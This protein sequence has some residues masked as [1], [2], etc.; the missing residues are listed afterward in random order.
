M[1]AGG[2]QRGSRDT[3]R[4]PASPRDSPGTPPAS[5]LLPGVNVPAQLPLAVAVSGCPGLSSGQ[6]ALRSE[7][8]STRSPRLPS[9]LPGLF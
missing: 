3:G 8:G 5:A 9:A 1:L 7:L 6:C 2:V 4:V